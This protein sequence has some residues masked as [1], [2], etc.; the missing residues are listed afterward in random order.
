MVITNDQEFNR[1]SI[2]CFDLEK[3]L[4]YANE[5]KKY[6]ANSLLYEALLIAAIVSYCRPFSP[7]EKTQNQQASSRVKVE[8]IS[9]LSEPELQIHS[10]CVKLRNKAIAH[11][12]FMM[13]P[14]RLDHSTGT[15]ISRPFSLL[16]L[17][18]DLMEFI[19][20]VNKLELACHNHR[21]SYKERKD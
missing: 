13:N 21:A 4:G 2:T 14:T 16:P 6:P 10:Y 5:A 7:N 11:S 8:N 20:L 18:F 17:P 15:I 12:E 3:T 19:G 1:Y 9:A